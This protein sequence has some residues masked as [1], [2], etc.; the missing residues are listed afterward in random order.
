MGP[1]THAQKPELNLPEQVAG[2]TGDRW[3]DLQLAGGRGV[4]WAG[5]RWHQLVRSGPN[6]TG[7]G[8]TVRESNQIEGDTVSQKV[9]LD[10]TAQF[11][12]RSVGIY[13]DYKVG[14]SVSTCEPALLY[15]CYFYG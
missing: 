11:W 10:R 5:D 14:R 15:E 3:Q 2:W 13:S 8:R 7:G 1:I 4:G 12:V 9:M 6:V